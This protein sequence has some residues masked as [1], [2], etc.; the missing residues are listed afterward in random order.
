MHGS[1]QKLFGEWRDSD[2]VGKKRTQRLEKTKEQGHWEWEGGWCEGGR[3]RGEC[4]GGRW[5][6]VATST[7]KRP[8]KR[9]RR[10]QVVWKQDLLE[11]CERLQG[12]ALL[13]VADKPAPEACW[14]SPGSVCHCCTLDPLT[15][16][17]DKTVSHPVFSESL[18]FDT[19]L[20]SSSAVND[21]FYLP[22]LAWHGL[23]GGCTGQRQ[24]LLQKKPHKL[25]NCDT[26]KSIWTQTFMLSA[27]CGS[28]PGLRQP[29][30]PSAEGYRWRKGEPRSACWWRCSASAWFS[31]SEAAIAGLPAKKT[32][33][34][35]YTL[36]KWTPLK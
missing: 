26:L 20:H 9:Q 21:G 25:W 34:P 17:R 7:L 29:L 11:Q 15:R 28:A 13:R 14:A 2:D 4:D 32:P 24:A 35:V 6:A 23:P 33:E 22:L 12:V 36:R 16:W 30:R 19:D 1:R 8:T 10:P 18:K 31:A 5:V 27:Q 3:C